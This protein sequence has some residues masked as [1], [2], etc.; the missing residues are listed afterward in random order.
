MKTPI[1]ERDFPG[2]LW[3]SHDWTL[4]E[5]IEWIEENLSPNQVFD[6][7]VLIKWYHAHKVGLRSEG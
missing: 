3:S 7:E 2:L 5:A 1:I 4:P 6:S